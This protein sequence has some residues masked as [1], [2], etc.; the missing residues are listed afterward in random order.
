VDIGSVLH[1]GLYGMQSSQTAMA[2]SAQTIARG[3]PLAGN[4]FDAIPS[5]GSVYTVPSASRALESR[6]RSQSLEEAM[7]SLMQQQ[8]VFDASAKVVRSADEAIGHLINTHA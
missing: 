4:V 8:H 5:S 3:Q 6:P 2:E 1:Q 7:T